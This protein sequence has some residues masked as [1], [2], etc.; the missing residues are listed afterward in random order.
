MRYR[1]DLDNEPARRNAADINKILDE[2][3][4]LNLRSLPLEA[5]MSARLRRR[6]LDESIKAYTDFTRAMHGSDQDRLQWT[7]AEAL[8]IKATSKPASP[9]MAK[10]RDLRYE[11]LRDEDQRLYLRVSLNVPCQKDCPE[12]GYCGP[13]DVYYRCVLVGIDEKPDASL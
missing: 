12:P 5:C 10:A 13:K 4:P 6:K 7:E 11:M 1:A 3:S 2:C 8:H 9:P